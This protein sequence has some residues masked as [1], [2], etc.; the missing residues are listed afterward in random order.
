MIIIELLS[1]LIISLITPLPVYDEPLFEAAAHLHR[2]STRI[3][4]LVIRSGSTCQNY[5]SFI[6]YKPRDDLVMIF[7]M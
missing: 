1:E 5:N 6:G 2:T 4:R 7:A 3:I